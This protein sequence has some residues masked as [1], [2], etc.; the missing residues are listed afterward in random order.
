MADPVSLGLIAGAVCTPGCGCGVTGLGIVTVIA[1]GYAFLVQVAS[2]RKTTHVR[3]VRSGFSACDRVHSSYPFSSAKLLRRRAKKSR[4][5]IFAHG[6]GYELY[7]HI[8]KKHG[9]PAELSESDFRGLQMDA[10]LTIG[11]GMDPIIIRLVEVKV[12]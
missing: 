12:A 5:D 1:G 9:P 2:S 6:L 4:P 3:F 11:S 8:H 10:L 7:Y